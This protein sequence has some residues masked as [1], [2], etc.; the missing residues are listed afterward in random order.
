MTKCFL[1]VSEMLINENQ[2]S[3]SA[4]P[5]VWSDQGP[6]HLL[7]WQRLYAENAHLM[8]LGLFN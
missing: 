5:L 3:L 7:K 6:S 4:P 2:K 8:E 1:E